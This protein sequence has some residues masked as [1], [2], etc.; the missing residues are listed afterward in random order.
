MPRIRSRYRFVE[1]SPAA[2]WL[3]KINSMLASGFD[4]QTAAAES[5]NARLQTIIE[6]LNSAEA[7]KLG[8]SAPTL[9]S[10]SSAAIAAPM[11]PA[12]PMTAATERAEILV[13]QVAVPDEE[14]PAF[15]FSR[16]GSAGK[17]KKRRKT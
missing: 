13:D 17:R 15:T 10:P 6:A 14:D 5:L 4:S 7:S 2:G 1:R 16:S 11:A 9:A 8:I 3:F 12:A